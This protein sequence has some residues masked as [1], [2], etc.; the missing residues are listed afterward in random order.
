MDIFFTV[1]FTA[2]LVFNLLAHWFLPFVTN[3]WFTRAH[4]HMHAGTHTHAL[5]L[6]QSHN[7]TGIHKI[8]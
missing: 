1:V 7:H 2:E 6:T 8:L 4:T 3:G 5:V